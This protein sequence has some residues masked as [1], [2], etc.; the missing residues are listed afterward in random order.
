MTSARH[1]NL[2]LC[3][4]CHKLCKKPPAAQTKAL[5]PRCYSPLFSRKPE[6]LI[7]TWALTIAA[8][9]LFIPANLLP[10]TTITYLGHSQPDTIMSGIIALTK[11]GMIPI[12]IVVFIASIAVPVLKLL[13]IVTLLLSVQYRWSMNPTQRT[14]MFRMI[15]WIGR[16]SMLD[17]FV[18]AI[19]M[20][21]INLGNLSEFEAGSAAN[22]FGLVVVLTM[23]AATS[24][25]PRLIWDQD[26]TTDDKEPKDIKDD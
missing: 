20:A 10:I 15:E 21:L 22:A 25:D 24:F 12:A 23:F 19:L 17:L 4:T 18:I 3:N 14:L 13:G 6:T 9:I 7:R 5:C 11:A 16:W 2:C 1:N 26:V 8:A